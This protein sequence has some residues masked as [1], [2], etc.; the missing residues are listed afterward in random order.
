MRETLA[1]AGMMRG[2]PT[3]HTTPSSTP[4]MPRVLS[5]QRFL[6]IRSLV[7]EL[8]AALDRVERHAA[9]ESIDL[10]EDIRWKLLAEAVAR[11]TAGPGRVDSVQELFS[12]AYDP[13]WRQTGG[14]ELSGSPGCCGR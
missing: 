10:D 13:A 14:P 8:S 2:S 3:D 6:T 11:L 5:D 1:G 9:E 12:D 4:L 7:V